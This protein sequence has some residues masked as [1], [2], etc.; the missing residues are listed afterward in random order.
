MVLGI[1]GQIAVVLYREGPTLARLMIRVLRGGR[2]S[3]ID[4]DSG[5]ED[6]DAAGGGACTQVSTRA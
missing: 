2:G 6:V 1:V 4:S 5:T 3:G